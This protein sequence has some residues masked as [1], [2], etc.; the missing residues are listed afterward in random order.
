MV[1]LLDGE[2]EGRWREAGTA[3]PAAVVREVDAGDEPTPGHRRPLDEGSVDV[4]EH[5]LRPAK[6]RERAVV[7]DVPPREVH[8]PLAELALDSGAFEVQ[9]AI[10][11][12]DIDRDDPRRLFGVARNELVR[13]AADLHPDM[14]V[15]AR[16]TVERP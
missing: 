10:T 3:G 15:V 13:V 14:H 8:E 9:R 7:A 12:D 16:R 1:G 5:E 2:R 6:H 11:V 4:A